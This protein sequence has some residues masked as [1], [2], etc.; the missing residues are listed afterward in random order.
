MSNGKGD[1]IRK[2]QV[3]EEQWHENWLLAFDKNDT[4]L[5]LKYDKKA[6]K[7]KI[8]V[9]KEEMQDIELDMM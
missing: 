9:S 1:R 8:I 2:R 6:K 3:P 5:N 4:E 7:W